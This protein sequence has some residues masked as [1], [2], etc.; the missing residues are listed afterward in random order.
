MSVII[1][2]N[3]LREID[4][5]R[6]VTKTYTLAVETAS[7]FTV[8]TGLVYVTSIVGKVATDITTAATTVRLQHNPTLGTTKDIATVSADIGTTDTV[9]G[10]ILTVDL[11]GSAA[12]AVTIGSKPISS[13]G[14]IL[15]PGAVEQ[16]TVAGVTGSVKWYLTYVPLDDG[17]AVAAA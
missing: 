13:G 8:S 17:A 9:T 4:L 3:E 12:A 2:G 7:L 11:N 16:V 14:I 1:N 10:E 15:A 5:G 6:L